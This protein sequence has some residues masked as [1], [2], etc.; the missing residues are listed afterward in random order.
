MT[1]T[2]K[3]SSQ[4]EALEN[5]FGAPL[6]DLYERAV[7][8]GASPALVRALELRSFLALAEEQ[9]VRVR[10]R[11]HASMAPD[12][13]LDQLSAEVLQSDVHWLEA[14]LD[15]RRGYR[16]ALDSLLSAMPPP[17][18]RPA[19]ALATSLPPAPPATSVEAGVLARGR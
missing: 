9:V 3:P 8:P 19:P 1:T 7:R 13:D 15:G 18:A 10:D 16:R 6:A 2:R 4:D 12:G 11:V 14:A 5:I 17:T